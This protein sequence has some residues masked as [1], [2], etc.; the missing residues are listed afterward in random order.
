MTYAVYG[1]EHFEKETEKLSNFDKGIIR[2]II[3][4]LKENPYIGEPLSYRFFREK[5]LREKRLYFL[6]YDDFN[7]VMLVA[8]GG[9]K[10]QQET[11]DEIIKFHLEFKKHLG[12]FLKKKLN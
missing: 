12:D 9:K 4:E 2:K 6:I 5:R 3:K 11:I 10:A 1:T 8:F 7:A